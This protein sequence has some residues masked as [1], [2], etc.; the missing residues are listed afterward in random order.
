M[1][2]VKTS[3]YLAMCLHSIIYMH[4]NGVAIEG[5]NFG[6]DYDYANVNT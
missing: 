6:Y 5:H 4:Q 3:E 2:S 1:N